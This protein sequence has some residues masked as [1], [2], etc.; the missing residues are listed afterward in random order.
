MNY[1]F[2]PGSVEAEISQQLSLDRDREHWSVPTAAETPKRERIIQKLDWIRAA[3][4]DVLGP[5]SSRAMRVEENYNT[6]RDFVEHAYKEFE[7]EGRSEAAFE[8][9]FLVPVRG[10]ESKGN[11]YASEVTKWLPLLD[12]S[13]GVGPME[14]QRTVAN[15]PPVKIEEY[16]GTG[17]M[18]GGIIFV[19]AYFDPYTFH[20]APRT[21]VSEI[22][23]AVQRRTSEAARL[24][25]QRYGMSLIGLGAVL[26][27]STKFGN[28]IQEPGLTATTGHAG[29]V[30]LVHETVK[31]VAEMYQEAPRVGV[32]G[33]GSIGGS[34]LDMLRHSD[35]N[36]AVRSYVIYDHDQHKTAAHFASR[37]GEVV[38]WARSELE[39]LR[40]SDIIVTAITEAID[41]DA[42]E[43]QTGSPIRLDGKVIIDDSQPGC[44]SREQVEARGGKLVWVVGQDN[45]SSRF[46]RRLGGY[47]FGDV[48]GFA[49]DAAAWG[50]EIEASALA[51]AGRKD[52]ATNSPVK[53]QA[54]IHVGGVASDVGMG[55]SNPLQSFG[56][57]VE[58]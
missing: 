39:L 3:N 42:L 21:F 22:I 25:R 19:P 32:L 50:C 18:Q 27:V 5:Q 49:F 52:L 43:I 2:E 46:L 51:V 15:L 13:N 28:S 11:E 45:S 8:W 37:N 29:T 48:S 16:A 1:L 4:L 33:L 20:H 56:Q 54:A 40:H 26:P 53:H 17:D 6:S 30:Y 10:D 7:A 14:L 31:A 38:I 9:G 41:L 58:F 23:P 12:P 55:V 47:R 44:F 57:T 24:A 34:S 35:I 36:Q